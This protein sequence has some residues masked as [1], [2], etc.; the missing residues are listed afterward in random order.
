MN[1]VTQPP[2]HHWC[3]RAGGRLFTCPF[4]PANLI[5]QLDLFWLHHY[6]PF[7]SSILTFRRHFLTCWPSLKFPTWNRLRLTLSSA[8]CFTHCILFY[9]LEMPRGV[10]H[11]TLNF[12]FVQWHKD[13]NT[14]NDNGFYQQ[15]FRHTLSKIC[16]VSLSSKG[17]SCFSLPPHGTQSFL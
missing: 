13:K 4:M 3:R 1:H 7:I 10:F 14:H 15:L 17:S 6:G 12:Y 2:L 5:S 9:S 8:I 16:W 11:V